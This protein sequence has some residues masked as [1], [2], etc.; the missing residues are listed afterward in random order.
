MAKNMWP[1]LPVAGTPLVE[2]LINDSDF[3]GLNVATVSAA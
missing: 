3:K 2:L 1:N